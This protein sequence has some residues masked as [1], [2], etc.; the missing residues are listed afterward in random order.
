MPDQTLGE[1]LAITIETARAAERELFGGLDRDAI[2]RP[3]RSGDWNP[4]DFQA[5]LTAWKD[6]HAERLARIREALEPL[7]RLE[8]QEEDEINAELRATRLDWSWDALVAEAD[9][10]A[11]R[12]A[13]ELRQADPDV[14]RG[15]DRLVDLT[16]GNGLLHTMSHIRWLLEAGIELDGSRVAQYE[17]DSLRLVEAP[18]LPERNRAAETYNLA[19]H[20]ALRGSLDIARRLLRDAFGTDPELLAFSRTDPDLEALRGELDELG[21]IAEGDGA[22]AGT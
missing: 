16:F 9:A 5:H 10:V 3:I 22:Q 14:L 13:G 12:L 11:A 2:E 1:A 7:A 21:G 6:R 15:P 4:K 20:H 18:A 17:A 8:G 19:C